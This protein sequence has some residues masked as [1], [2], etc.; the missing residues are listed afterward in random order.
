MTCLWL[1]ETTKRKVEEGNKTLRFVRR[2][3]ASLSSLS[4]QGLS[5]FA[6][7]Q[8]CLYHEVSDRSAHEAENKQTTWKQALR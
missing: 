5:H 3:V 1:E 2:L 6:A 4:T 8:R 7:P